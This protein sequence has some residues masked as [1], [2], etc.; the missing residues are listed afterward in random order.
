MTTAKITIRG[1]NGQI[2]F[3]DDQDRGMFRWAC[4]LLPDHLSNDLRTYERCGKAV[5]FTFYTDRVE[6]EAEAWDWNHKQ[7]AV[8]LCQMYDSYFRRKYQRT[9]PQTNFEIT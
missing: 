1:S 8:F 7:I 3:F 6:I 2:I 4:S 5:K 9:G